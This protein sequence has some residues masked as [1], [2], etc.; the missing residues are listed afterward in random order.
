MLQA[1]CQPCLLWLV[2][3]ARS[4]R[5][6]HLDSEDEE[7]NDEESSVEIG[8][9]SSCSHRFSKVLQSLLR[10]PKRWALRLARSCRASVSWLTPERLGI[11]EFLL[12]ADSLSPPQVYSSSEFLAANSNLS[13]SSSDRSHSEDKEERWDRHS[14]DED[15]SRLA[16]T[17]PRCVLRWGMQC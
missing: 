2:L 4:E 14:G 9:F 3:S 6:R 17:E 16:G 11:P 8:Q 5:Y 1:G 10:H 12:L 7:T 15:R 13:L